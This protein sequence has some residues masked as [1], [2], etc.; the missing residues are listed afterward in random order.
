MEAAWICASDALGSVTSV[1]AGAGLT[2]GP[3]TSTGSLA[4]ATGGVTAAMLAGN[5]CVNGQVLKYNGS[6]WQCAADNTPI[7]AFVQH[8]NAFGAEATLGTNDPFALNLK[9]GGTAVMRFVWNGVS[10]NIIGGH[11]NYAVFGVRGA[12][13]GGGGVIIG[14]NDPDYDFEAPNFVSDH[15]GTI[16]GGYANRVG[17]NGATLN[18]QPFAVIAGGAFNTASGP[19]AAITGGGA[20]TASGSYAFVGGGED[21]HAG[22]ASASDRRRRAQSCVWPL[23]GVAG[24]Y[25]N[26][27]KGYAASVGGGDDNIAEGTLPRTIP[28]GRDNVAQGF[29]SFAAGV[30]AKALSDFCFVWSGGLTGR[31]ATRRGSSSPARTA[32]SSCSRLGDRHPG[33]SGRGRAGPRPS[34][35]DAKERFEDVDPVE[36]LE[37]LWRSIARWSYKAE[38]SCTSHGAGRS[39]LSHGVP[40]RR[41]RAPHCDGRRRRRSAGCHP[42]PQCK[43]RKAA[44]GAGCANCGSHRATRFA[45][46]GR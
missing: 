21:N 34:D 32:A 14:N 28:G 6:A 11:A 17:D 2:G 25:A 42:R 20:N 12:T 38:R 8:G 19:Y 22:N 15:Y 7:N 33:G 30:A 29:G 24:G 4:I 37:R 3:I 35:R 9:T 39:G 45:A 31:R 41:Q 26:Q 44:A 46:T 27:A 5:G 23:S 16:G 43:A 40:T 13:I 10:P 18:D 1:S 36:V